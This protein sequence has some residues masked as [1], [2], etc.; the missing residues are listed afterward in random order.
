MLDRSRE[1][2]WQILNVARPGDALSHLFDVL[3]ITLIIVNVVALIV[4]TVDSVHRAA[5]RF[6]AWI[7]VVSVLIFTVEYLLR[8]WSCTADPLYRSPLTGRLRWAITPLALIDLLAVLPFYLPFMGVDLR[9]TRAARLFRIFR[10]ARLTR[11]SQAL[12]VLQ[13]VIARRKEELIT[14]SFILLLLLLV[15]ASLMYFAEND[16]QP[17]VFSSIP[18]AMWWAVVTLTTVGYGDVYPVTSLGRMLAAL[19]AVL[20]IAML[21][22]P[23]SILGA[24]FA[25]EIAAQREPLHCPHCGREVRERGGFIPGR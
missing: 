19:V 25:E 6:F 11:Y 21:A 15:A 13:R 24:S 7:N 18:A 3:L 23:T 8:L 4:E 1:R 17:Q 12:H 9:F 20:G 22:V 10:M 14:T 16:V 2:V 5:P